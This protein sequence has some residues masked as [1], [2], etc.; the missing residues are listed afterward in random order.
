MFTERFGTWWPAEHHIGAADLADAIIEPRVGGRYYERGVD[1][2]ECDWGR[3]LAYDP[4][5]PKDVFAK[6]GVEYWQRRQSSSS[7]SSQST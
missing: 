6:A 4:F 2:S 7:P 5:V 3:V 1:G